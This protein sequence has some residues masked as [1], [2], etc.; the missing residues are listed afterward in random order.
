MHRSL[1]IYPYADA[2]VFLADK[3]LRQ[4]NLTSDDY[5]A[6]VEYCDYALASPAYYLAQ[7][8]LRRAHYLRAYAL[9]ELG[10]YEAAAETLDRYLAAGGRTSGEIERLRG[11]IRAKHNDFPSAIHL[12]GESLKLDPGNA[13]TLAQ[14]GSVYVAIGALD[15]ALADFRA[16]LAKDGKHA[17]ALAGRGLVRALRGDHEGAEDDAERAWALGPQTQRYAWMAA[18]TLAIVH[19][20]LQSRGRFVSVEE[21]K[22]MVRYRQRVVALLEQ[23]LLQAPQGERPAYWRDTIEADAWLSLLRD[24][25][26]FQQLQRKYAP[27]LKPAPTL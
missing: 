12:F 25:P 24:Q 14:R 9:V 17:N 22:N 4:S 3:R 6:V 1:A 18:R 21:S 16:A 8:P 11:S 15:L 20:R 13:D 7:N 10:R 23:A 5:D 2:Q 26:A 19:G 27:A